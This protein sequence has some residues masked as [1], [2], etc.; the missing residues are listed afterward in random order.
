MR[1]GR[2]WLAVALGAVLLTGSLIDD[3]A[4]R[5]PKARLSATVAGKRLK[6]LRRATFLIYSTTS[7]SV[8][9]QTNVRHGLSRAVSAACLGDLKTLVLPTTLGCYGT[10]T[11]ARRSGARDWQ[12]NEGMQVTIASFDGT[13]AV[14]T[15]QGTLDPGPSHAA[16]PTVG[17]EN[18]AFSIV[19]RESGV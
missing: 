8:T 9:G 14:G 1:R 17:V 6:A 19:I 12:R 10:Y 15:F 16:D 18:G 7:F 5:K 3:A 11:E 4:A 2:S 13:R